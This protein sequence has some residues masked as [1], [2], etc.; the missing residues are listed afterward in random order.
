[1]VEIKSW[2]KSSPQKDESTHKIS[3]MQYL[4]SLIHMWVMKK[5]LKENPTGRRF[6]APLILGTI[7]TNST[8]EFTWKCS[9]STSCTRRNDTPQD[10][11]TSFNR[12]R[13]AAELR[14]RISLGLRPHFALITAFANLG[15]CEV[16]KVCG[17]VIGEWWFLMP[18]QKPRQPPAVD[19]KRRITS[20]RLMKK[21]EGLLPPRHP[22][23]GE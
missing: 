11:P 12:C 8:F 23:L 20:G 21:S 18:G 16:L 13:S 7:G 3:S 5:Y 19:A 10:I 17:I 2:N 4:K 6:Y 15:W 9:P 14:V 22:C 1:M